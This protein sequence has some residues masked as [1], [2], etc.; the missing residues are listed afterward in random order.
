MIVF[1]MQAEFE[2]WMKNY[3]DLIAQQ[4]LQYS[5][6]CRLNSFFFK[7]MNWWEMKMEKLKDFQDNGLPY[8]LNAM[9]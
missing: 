1:C 7:W 2:F 9:M 6:V 5:H 3:E 4:Q 8:N